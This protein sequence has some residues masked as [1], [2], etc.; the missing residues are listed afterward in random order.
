MPVKR[1][2]DFI[3]NGR[4]YMLQRGQYKGRAWTRIGRSDA[5]GVRSQTDAKWGVLDDE[6]DHPE[7]WDD[8]SGGMGYAYRKPGEPTYHWAEN[9]DARFPRQLVHC[10]APRLFT[11]ATVLSG[12]GKAVAS[13]NH[14]CNYM[15]DAWTPGSQYQFLQPTPPRNQ[16]SV[17]MCGKGFIAAITPTQSGAGG[18]DP[19]EVT[20]ANVDN[21][22]NWGNRIGLSSFGDGQLVFG[23]LSG[24][25]FYYLYQD[26]VGGTTGSGFGDP[27][28]A[29]GFLNAGSRLYRWHGAAGNKAWLLQQVDNHP[30]VSTL[31]TANWTATITIGGALFPIL[32]GVAVE[33]QAFFGT[34]KGLYAGDLSGTFVNVLPEIENRIHA[35]NCRDLTVH[36]N[37]VIAPHVGGV[38]AFESNGYTGVAREIGPL[39]GQNE[40]SPLRG[41]V[42]AV[43]GVGPWLLGGLWTGSQSW[44]L[45]GEDMGD[46]YRWH[47]LNRLPHTTM[48]GRLHLDGITIASSGAAIPNRLWIAGEATGGQPGTTMTGPIYWMPQPLNMGNPLAAWPAGSPNYVGS[49][50]IDLG[51]VDWG[52]PGTPKLY[53]AVE[54]WADNLASGAQWAKVYYSVDAEATRHLLGTTAQSPKDIMY[55]PSGEGSF[56]TGQSIALSLESFTASAG[57]TPVYRS[58][59][60]RGALQARSVD[61][62]TA[63]VRIADGIRDRQGAEMRSGATM[64]KELRDLGNADITPQAVQLVDLAGATQYVKVM[65][66]VDEQ[67]VYQQG[68]EEPEI[69]ATVKLAVMSYTGGAA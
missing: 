43:R 8:W 15:I 50:R 21:I 60:L 18:N 19:F 30:D 35:D 23:E 48:I 17:I 37:A 33:D 20:V 56:V 36:N 52:A 24:K 4:G 10:Q 53:R 58:I 6:L 69:A 66:R 41:H 14:N 65:A 3:L 27:M 34:A 25:G 16:R 67:E 38:F 12:F 63:V 29:A 40:R 28:P 32:D 62:I 39:T 5:P 64:L 55:F 11:S 22:S 9:F 44:L 42:R 46:R 57:V 7:A 45:A 47:T 26:R 31:A 54:V 59:V 1:R 68:D 49:A 51:S 13:I 2:F 61:V